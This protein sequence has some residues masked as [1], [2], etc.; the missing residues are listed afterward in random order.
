MTTMDLGLEVRVE[1]GLLRG[2][3][4]DSQGVLAFKSIPYAAPPVGDLRWRAPQPPQ[5]WDGVREAVSYGDR[6]L[7]ALEND[8]RPG[9]PMS[10]NCLS[11]NLWTAASRADE[12]RPVMVW[13]HGGGFQFGSSATPLTDGTPLA[14]KGVVVVTFNYRLGVLGFL[15]HPDLDAEGPSGNYG[16]QDQL[17]ALAWVKANISRFGGDPSNVTLFGESAGAHAVGILTA[18]PLSH[19]LFHKVIGQSGAFW[20]GRNGPLEGFDE[21]RARGIAFAKRVGGT[22]LA[23][24]RAMPAEQ[25]NAAGLWNFTQ[26]PNVKA[27]SPNIDRFVVPDVPAARFARGE[28]MHIPL[29]AGWNSAEDYPFHEMSLPD[30][31]APMFRAAAEQM[32]GA[33]RISEFLKLYPA[34]TDAEAKA[35]SNALTGDL[36]ISEQ[37]WQWLQ[38]HQRTGQAPVYGYH[39]SYTSPYTPIA[40]HVT[41]IPFVF[42]TLTQQVIVGGTPSPADGDRA[43]ADT[44]MSY[45]VNF[46]TRGDPN[47]PGLPRWP[48]YDESDVVQDL[49]PRVEPRTNPQ[50]ARFRFIASF[51]Q[52]GVLPTRWRQLP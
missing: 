27:F 15:A 28:Q 6:S 9:P 45:W 13:V 20:D 50:A 16:L 31:S 22:S 1:A 21:A 18:S 43:L 2:A 11:L 7:S 47:G 51:R 44:I 14:C 46:A 36:L 33:D 34:D 42:G 52:G 37:T 48:R 4:R 38:L 24:L 10:E 25:A 19:G 23:A 17:A 29:L 26:N 8:R 40:S 32:F 35:S 3:P 49:G 39:F 5:P 30:D 41:E 12:K